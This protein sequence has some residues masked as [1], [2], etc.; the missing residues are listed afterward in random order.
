VRKH[1]PLDVTS[2]SD[3]PDWDGECMDE[4]ESH[5]HTQHHVDNVVSFFDQQRWWGCWWRCW[6]CWR[7]S[8]SRCTAAHS[9]NDTRKSHKTQCIQWQ[10]HLATAN[11]ES[12]RPLFGYCPQL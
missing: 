11:A 2:C 9:T 6:W 5:T 12:I 1:N 4:D 3:D 10:R 7:F 8:R